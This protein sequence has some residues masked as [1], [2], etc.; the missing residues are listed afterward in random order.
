MKKLCF[1]LTAAL[2]TWLVV[3]TLLD[4]FFM[5]LGT[6]CAMITGWLLSLIHI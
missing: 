6:F 4:L 5:A 2:L 1:M 3:V